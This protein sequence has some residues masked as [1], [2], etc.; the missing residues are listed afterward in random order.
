[1]IATSPDWKPSD[2]LPT[3]KWVEAAKPPLTKREVTLER[4]RLKESLRRAINKTV[5]N[6]N[7]LER[8]S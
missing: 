4:K 2:Y 5:K 1:M 3:Q 6:L 8:V 7:A